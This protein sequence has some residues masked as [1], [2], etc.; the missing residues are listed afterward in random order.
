MHSSHVYNHCFIPFY[1]VLYIA[2][3]L[4][5]NDATFEQNNF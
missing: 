1:G 4:W 5:Q 3:D 2:T